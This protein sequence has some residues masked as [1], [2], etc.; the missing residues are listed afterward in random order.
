[1]IQT[2][3]KEAVDV[4]FLNPVKGIFNKPTANIIM[5]DEALNSSPKFGNKLSMFT[6]TTTKNIKLEVLHS[7][8]EQEK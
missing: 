2:L 5:N 8:T 4:N 3:S 1:M 7:A 6:L